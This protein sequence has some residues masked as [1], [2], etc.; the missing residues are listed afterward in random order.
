MNITLDVQESNSVISL[1]H[2]IVNDTTIPKMVRKKKTIST[3]CD[4][5]KSKAI[6][7]MNQ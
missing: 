5:L 2:N 7:Q 6:F 3:V 4:N 1:H